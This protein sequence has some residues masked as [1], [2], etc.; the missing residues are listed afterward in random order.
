LA[1]AVTAGHLWLVEQVVPDRLGDGAAS[2]TSRMARMDVAFVRE[3]APAAPPTAAP[4][5]AARPVRQLAVPAAPSASQPAAQ[6]AEEPP[7]QPATQPPEITPAPEP[8]RRAETPAEPLPAVETPQPQAAASAASASAST[9]VFEWPPSTRLSYR[10]SGNFR[11]PVEG[12]ARVEWLRAGTRY[13]VHMD[14]GVG[15]SFAPLLSR[16]VS[17]EGEITADG[18]YPQRYDE[19]TRAL[20]R[21]PRRLVVALDSDT[22]HL[23]DG[24][25]IRRPAGVQD[26]ASQ[27][28]Q[29]T[30]LF[31]TQPERLQPGQSIDIP[32][33]L[34]RRLQVWTYDVLAEETLQTPFGPVP[35]VHVKPRREARPGTDLVAEVWFAPSLQFLPVRILIRQDVDNYVDLMIERLPQQAGPTPPPAPA[36]PGS[37]VPPTP[38][39]RG[40]R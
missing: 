27:F 24:V 5:P 7:V 34:P 35:T 11:G 14:L 28:V 8:E 18:L 10:L 6:P 30:W 38:A 17:S 23:S 9:T 12:Q 4:R 36:N 16:R 26:S 39:Q 21:A 29:L 13:Q 2:H 20:L 32:L 22:V 3:L 15:P 19:E 31:S 25:A 37:I 40:E 33:A 1:A